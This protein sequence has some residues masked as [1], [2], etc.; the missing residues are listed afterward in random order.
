MRF[1]PPLGSTVLKALDECLDVAPTP[2]FLFDVTIVDGALAITP[3]ERCDSRET[4]LCDANSAFFVC[5]RKVAAVLPRTASKC[6]R[7]FTFATLL[8]N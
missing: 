3:R 8:P 6:W 5:A 7:G 1:F 2:D 4:Y